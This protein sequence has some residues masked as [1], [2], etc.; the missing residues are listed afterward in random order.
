MEKFTSSNSGVAIYCLLAMVFTFT[1]CQKDDTLEKTDSSQKTFSLVR[2]GDCRSDCIAP[3]GPYFD[4]QDL[5]T[6][7]WGGR[8]GDANTKTVKIKYYNTETH[9]VI[10]VKSTHSWSDLIINGVSSWTN[11]PVAAE[12][13]GVYSVPLDADW[14]ACDALEFKLEVAGQGPPVGFNIVYNLIGVCDDGCDTEFTGEALACGSTREA[15]YTFTPDADHDYIKIQ[16]GLTNFTGDDAVVT[17]TGGNLSVSQSTPGGS[18]NRVIKVEGS[19]T[20]CETVVIHVVWNS[21]S[22]GGITTGSWSVKDQNSIDLAPAVLGL[23]CQ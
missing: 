2:A 22:S 14:Q 12:T 16:G 10:E 18:S 5:Q 19:V 1:A 7:S 6:I 20:E 23:Q 4:V 21:T 11:G 17:V 8:Y 15:V 3:G 13:W 9:L